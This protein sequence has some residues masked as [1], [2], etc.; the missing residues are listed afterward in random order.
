MRLTP[1]WPVAGC[2]L[3]LGLW[4]LAGCR[5][6]RPALAK[7]T[8]IEELA[9][10]LTQTQKPVARRKGVLAELFKTPEGTQKVLDYARLG[11][12]PADLRLAAA[13]ELGR[14]PWPALRAQGSNCLA[15]LVTKDGLPL[16]RLPELVALR[17]HPSE[18]EKVY[19]RT[20][21]NCIGCHMV[22]G[23]GVAVGSD[24]SDIGKRL[25]REGILENILDP[26]AIITANYETWQV[27][28]KNNDE[29]YGLLVENSDAELVIKD[30][31]ASLARVK[32]SE[33][34]KFQQVPVSLMPA[35]LQA[36][37][38]LQELVDLL[39]Y[40]CSLTKGASPP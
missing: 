17:G 24:L 35:G 5:P 26:S 27:I 1:N 30:A 19:Q 33:V 20:D 14:S 22:N 10:Q 13:L 23:Q 18:G 12:L 7:Q 29:L 15:S 31:K 11:A 6:E 39:E 8:T 36:S 4:A 34:K 25:D 32:K 3:L 2:L 40:L 28:L 16:P 9:A 38:S 37:M 21:L